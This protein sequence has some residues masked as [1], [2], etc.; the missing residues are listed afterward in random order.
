MSSDEMMRGKKSRV[1]VGLLT[2]GWLAIA[3]GCSKPCDDLA[4]RVCEKSGGQSDECTKASAQASE[5]NTDDQRACG[6]VMDMVETLSR[7]K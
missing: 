7:H 1:L 2:V 5:A 6:R 3:M 4:E